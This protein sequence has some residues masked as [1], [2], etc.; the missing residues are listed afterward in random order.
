MILIRPHALPL[1]FLLAQVLAFHRAVLFSKRY[2]IPWDMVDYHLPL[3]GFFA[4]CLRDGQAPLWDPYTYCGFPFFAN[5]DAQPFYPPTWIAIALSNLAGGRHLL[6]FLEWQLA[7]HVFLGGAFAYFLLRRLALGRGPAVLGA[8]VFQLGGYFAS[9]A[10]HLAAMNGGVWLPLVW[11]SVFALRDGFSWRWLA[12]A[13]LGFAMA[14]LAGYP[15]V[16]AVVFGSAFLLALTLVGLRQARPRLLVWMAAASALAVGLSAIQLLPTWELNQLSIA[17]HRGEWTDTAGGVP[18]QALVS[19]LVPN[20]YHIFD[21]SKYSL[22]WNP[23]FLYLYC[24]LAGVALAVGAVLR[25]RD[26]L[27]W[28][29]LAVTALSAVWMMGDHTPVLRLLYPRLPAFVRSPLYVDFAM[30]SFQLGMACLAAL[31]AERFL[32]RRGR[33]V[34]AAV[35]LLAAADL[36]AVGSRRPMNCS[37]LAENPIVTARAFE[38]SERVL[39]R[40]RELV[41]QT[42]P[43]AR[44]EVYRDSVRWAHHSSALE[45]PTANGNEPLALERLLDLRRI[46]GEGDWWGRSFEVKAIGSPLLDLLN[47]R[48]LVSWERSL[49]PVLEGGKFRQVAE[50][51]N[52]RVYENSGALPRFFLVDDVRSAGNRE[53]AVAALRSPAFDPRRQA[54]VEGLPGWGRAAVPHSFPP[55]RVLRYGLRRVA[56]E[57]ESAAPAFLVTSETYYPGWRA[58]LDGVPRPLYLTNVAFRG[59]PVPAGRHRVEMYF[60]PR[61]LPVSAA[62]TLATLALMLLPLAKASPPASRNQ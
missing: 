21:L 39:S 53:E 44:M 5:I 24:G 26:R 62:I 17:H 25:S 61:I 16:T 33:W 12:T 45:I 43:P 31:G 29:F 54:I 49:A 42:V 4:R 50:V 47:V 14:T 2:A 36:I 35:A 15:A 59:L 9:Q 8:T 55:V 28:V 27:R 60:S 34:T 13:A 3:A 40:L 37:S 10:Q 11:L 20:F 51:D 6:G 30:L 1:L 22:P 23:T 56:L 18:P 57:T 58:W 7:L 52:H 41:N 48:Y 38:G 32:A 19:L 46:F